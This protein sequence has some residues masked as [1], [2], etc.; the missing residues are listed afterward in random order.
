MEKPFRKTTLKT[1]RKK[2]P[3]MKKRL[4]APCLLTLASCASPTI[5]VATPD[6]I[7]VDINMR[8][9]VY[10]HE[11]KNSANAKNK[12]QQKDSSSTPESR[13]RNRMGDIQELKNS[14]LVGEGA[15]G[16]LA[17]V[18]APPGDFGIF[19][20]KTV[21][22]ENADRME[23]MKQ[24]SEKTKRSLDAIQN[25]QAAEWRNRSF[26]GEWIQLPA[27][28]QPGKFEWKQKPGA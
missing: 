4:L 25:E 24:I 1:T 10:Q 27:E 7:Q 20:R 6:P 15:D 12:P 18:E 23:V 9:D 2:Q 26:T 13:R 28:G 3:P 22:E 21:N 17:I 5:Q 14:R 8:V 11:P 19:V 16:L